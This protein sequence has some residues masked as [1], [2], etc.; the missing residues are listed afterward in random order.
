MP[1]IIT[2][3]YVWVF[4]NTKTHSETIELSTWVSPDRFAEHPQKTTPH[5]YQLTRNDIRYYVYSEVQL[6]QL[7]AIKVAGTLY[8]AEFVIAPQMRM[9]ALGKRR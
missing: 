9:K 3:R 2:S 8:D 6:S 1:E 4:L 7:Q 5:Y